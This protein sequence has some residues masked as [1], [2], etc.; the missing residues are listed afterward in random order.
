MTSFYLG[1]S[2]RR[3]HNQN[4]T[5]IRGETTITGVIDTSRVE[6]PAAATIIELDSS[7]QTTERTI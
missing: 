5:P 3:K 2:L 4:C 6:G 7:N 1:F